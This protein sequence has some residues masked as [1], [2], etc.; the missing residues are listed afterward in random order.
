MKIDEITCW[1]GYRK[2]GTQAGTGKNKGKRVNKCVKEEDISEVAPIV[3]AGAI[4][5]RWVLGF[6]IKR[7]GVPLIKWLAK[8]AFKWGLV[9]AGAIKAAEWGWDIVVEYLG[10]E[11]AGWLQEN[12]VE[13]ATVVVLI[14]A[15]AKLKN[16]I[17][18]KMYSRA[19]ATEMTEMYK[20]KDGDYALD[21][22]PKP[23][24][25]KRGPHPL[26][27]KLVG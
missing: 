24:K 7:G 10:E 15:A 2:S 19:D 12:A 3:L 26:G 20:Q 23:T 11:I 21:S 4:A 16:Y 1:K 14:V 8:K 27:G 13:L 18:N 17:E 25:K 22:D 9:S 6:A 5:A